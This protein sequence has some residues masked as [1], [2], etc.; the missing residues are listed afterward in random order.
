MSSSA[1]TR[2]SAKASRNA[3]DMMVDLLRRDQESKAFFRRLG[4]EERQQGQGK[5]RRTA[6]RMRRALAGRLP[7]PNV[8][9]LRK[10]ANRAEDAA[11]QI[12]NE[13][14]RRGTVIPI[15]KGKMRFDKQTFD[16]TRAA[17]EA[18][19]H[20]MVQRHRRTQR[21]GRGKRGGGTRRRSA[22]PRTRSQRRRRR[23]R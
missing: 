16:A 18:K 4:K 19:V 12:W 8:T 6:R 7:R 22:R 3:K 14:E 15:V 23:S 17:A 13:L 1:S 21:K 11:E 9:F 2:S 20:G 5:F 10:E